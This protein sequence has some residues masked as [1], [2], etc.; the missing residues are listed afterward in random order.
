MEIGA[1][2]GAL[3]PRFLTEQAV[4]ALARLGFRVVEVM[5]QTAG[6]Y[7][8]AFARAVAARARVAGLEVRSVHT[9]TQLHPVFATYRRRRDEAIAAFD[10]VID[11]AATLGARYLV[12]HGLTLR[13]LQSGVAWEAFRT[14]LA[15]LA[16]RCAGSGVTLTIE[17]VSW[18]AVRDAQGVATV[19]GWR[20]PVG[21]TLDPFQAVEAGAE[22]DGL[23][24][25]M[26]DA[27]VNVHVSD[28]APGGRRHLPLGE[29]EID[30]GR[31]LS[32][33]RE[34][35]YAGPLVLEMACEGDLGV[36][37]ESRERLRGLAGA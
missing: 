13:D 5:L 19:R 36:L 31:I 30:W 6:E 3:Y 24:G 2:T 7:E 34:S 37:T 10:R 11:A 12:W 17:N 23:I 27:L 26:G 15:D 8:P 9:Q 21:F 33:L 16:G 18:C 25:A 22:P 35:G 29:G 20:L 14:A 1:S 28:H 32:R 4:E